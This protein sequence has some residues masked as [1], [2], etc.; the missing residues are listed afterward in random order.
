MDCCREP[1]HEGLGTPASESKWLRKLSILEAR[2]PKPRRGKAEKEENPLITHGL[3]WLCDG[4]AI[5]LYGIR[6]HVAM[7]GISGSR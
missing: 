2:N 5:L 3:L 1:D 6:S 4:N 7:S